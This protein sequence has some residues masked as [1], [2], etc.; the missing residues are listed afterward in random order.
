VTLQYSLSRGGPAQV[1]IYDV[2]GRRVRT[3]LNDS[4]DIG[5]GVLVWD[6]RTESGA[7]APGG[8]YLA[9]LT[10]NGQQTITKLVRVE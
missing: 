9:R 5:T 8:V 6:G 3:L 4:R 1:D 7:E 2:A 10:A